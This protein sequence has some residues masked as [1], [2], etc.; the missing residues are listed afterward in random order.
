MTSP[1]TQEPTTTRPASEITGIRS[2]VTRMNQIAAAHDSISNDE[3]FLGSLNR[4]EV[5]ADHQQMVR[6]AQAASKLA[7]AAWAYAAKTIADH[8][9]PLQEAYTNNPS[10][11]N[12]H[13]NTNE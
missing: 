12:K 9:L 8:N 3:G 13:A 11:A 7:A 10:A 6:D 2:G 5:G 4:M 1:A